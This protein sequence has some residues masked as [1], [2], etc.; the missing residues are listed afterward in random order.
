MLGKPF[1]HELDLAVHERTYYTAG[2]KL[3]RGGGQW[4]A[5]ERGE[6]GAFTHRDRARNVPQSRSSC[7][8]RGVA[9][10]R[11]EC[12]ECLG[13]CDWFLVRMSGT[14]P[15]LR[16]CNDRQGFVRSDRPVGA[17]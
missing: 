3:I 10:K 17:D 8:V 16:V 5:L 6:V 1:Q 11:L 9:L 14:A 12:G 2:G 7:G 15:Q 4:I 13:R